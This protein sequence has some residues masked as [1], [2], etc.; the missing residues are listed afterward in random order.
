MTT[1]DLSPIS[2]ALFFTQAIEVDPHD[3]P[4]KFR[5]YYTPSVLPTA[6]ASGSRG[7]KASLLVCHHGAGSAGTTFSLLAK[8]VVKKSNGEL[9]V[10]A[11]DARGHG[12]FLEIQ[13]ATV[14]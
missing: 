7:K 5:A 14:S 1:S 10:L 4:C 8:E 9:G 6:V 13:M 3:S 12:M 2:P 11:F